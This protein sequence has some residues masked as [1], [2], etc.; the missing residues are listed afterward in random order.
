MYTCVHVL[1]IAIQLLVKNNRWHCLRSFLNVGT[2]VYNCRCFL[3]R[4]MT[5]R[6]KDRQYKNKKV[7]KIN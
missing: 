1:C 6:N 5:G 2:H 4:T 3:S 7:T